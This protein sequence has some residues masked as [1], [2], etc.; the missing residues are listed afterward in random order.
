MCKQAST[1]ICSYEKRSSFVVYSSLW[2]VITL[3]SVVIL[4]LRSFGSI[5]WLKLFFFFLHFI[6]N[7]LVILPVTKSHR[8]QS[9]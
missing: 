5:E 3:L 8:I 9:V 1:V 2:C 7:C 6:F 4:I